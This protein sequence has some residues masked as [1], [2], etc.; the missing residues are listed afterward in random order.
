MQKVVVYE[1]KQE[2]LDVTPKRST[3]CLLISF[4]KLGSL[5]LSLLC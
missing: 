3:V 4:L 5:D 2:R 1:K